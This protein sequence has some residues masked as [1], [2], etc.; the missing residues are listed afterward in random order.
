MLAKM[1]WDS[2]RWWGGIIAQEST[3]KCGQR[4]RF[5]DGVAQGVPHVT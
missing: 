5:P 1:L 3:E 2:T 4:H